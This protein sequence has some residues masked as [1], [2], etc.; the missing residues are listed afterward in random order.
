L[1]AV[2]LWLLPLPLPLLSP[3]PLLPSLL[4]SVRLARNEGLQRACGLPAAIGRIVAAPDTISYNAAISA[5]G[6]GASGVLGR[7]E[8]VVF[9][10]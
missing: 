8:P 1:V 3:L 4:L 9:V 5:C 10:D 2:A 6:E 7:W